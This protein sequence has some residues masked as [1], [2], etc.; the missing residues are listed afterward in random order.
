MHHF[1]LAWDPSSSCCIIIAIIHLNSASHSWLHTKHCT[2]NWSI[3]SLSLDCI[4]INRHVLQSTSSKIIQI[5]NSEQEYFKHHFVNPL[6]YPYLLSMSFVINVTDIYHHHVVILALGE[7]DHLFLSYLVKLIY[8]Q[9]L[10]AL[11]YSSRHA[12]IINLNLL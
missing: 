11:V 10:H 5:I 4:G 2:L 6:Y 12:L 3:L 8:V 1:G 7:L 9:S